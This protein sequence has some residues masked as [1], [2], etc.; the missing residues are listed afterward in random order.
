MTGRGGRGCGPTLV[1]S[2][3]LKLLC[4]LDHIF[5]M[6]KSLSIL[7]D[8]SFHLLAIGQLNKVSCPL[9]DE[10]EISCPP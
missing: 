3:F 2:Q 6:F 7:C 1:R 8:A 5:F 10:N 4:G 9:R